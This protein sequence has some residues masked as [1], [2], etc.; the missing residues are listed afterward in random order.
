MAAQDYW[1]TGLRRELAVGV[2]NALLVPRHRDAH[3]EVQGRSTIE[4]IVAG[5]GDRSSLIFFPEGTRG[6]GEAV[7]PFKSGLYYLCQRKPELQLVPAYL[8][9]LNRILPKG[10][11]LPVPF[12]SKLTFGHP[13]YL[14][15]RES[16]PR[17]LERMRDAVCELR[18]Q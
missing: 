12:I 1:D 16:K 18:A 13:T 17:F 10:Q 3:S 14:E 2:F 5:I 11:F 9:N 7:A 15:P 6:T 4:Q 8:E